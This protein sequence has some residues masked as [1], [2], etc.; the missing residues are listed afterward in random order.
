MKEG[1]FEDI[2]KHEIEC[3]VCKDCK[4]KCTVCPAEEN[5]VAYFRNGEEQSHLADVEADKVRK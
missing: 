5:C 4:H 2:R 1:T 3:K